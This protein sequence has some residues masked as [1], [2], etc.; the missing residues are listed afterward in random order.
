[1]RDVSLVETIQLMQTAITQ[2]DQALEFVQDCNPEFPNEKVEALIVE[3]I[4][5]ARNQIADARAAMHGEP[6]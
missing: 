2:A 5:R 3:Q 6:I 4:Q 1:M